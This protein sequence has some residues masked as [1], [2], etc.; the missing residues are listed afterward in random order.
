MS[1]KLYNSI[2]SINSDAHSRYQEETTEAV[3]KRSLKTSTHGKVYQNAYFNY[4]Q[5]MYVDNCICLVDNCIFVDSYKLVYSDH[6]NLKCLL[7]DIRVTLNDEKWTPDL[8]SGNKIIV[9]VDPYNKPSIIYECMIIEKTASIVCI[10]GGCL[11]IKND[12]SNILEFFLQITRISSKSPAEAN[13]KLYKIY[14]YSRYNISNN[15]EED[16]FRFTLTTFHN[17][18]LEEPMYEFSST[19][20][21]D[22][23]FKIP[24]FFFYPTLALENSIPLLCGYNNS[25]S[26]FTTGFNIKTFKGY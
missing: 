17:K 23:F 11:S 10:H 22:N 5:P 26:L 4:S 20:Y 13:S 15:N 6:T 16:N 3:E 7:R 25:S 8:S 9:S 12:M 14:Y 1:N 21:F 18:R 2:N 19:V 24:S